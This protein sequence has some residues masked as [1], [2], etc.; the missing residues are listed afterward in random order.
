MLQALLASVASIQSQQTRMSVIGNNLANVNT[1]AYK[2][3]DL[4]FEDMISQ[5]IQGATAPSGNLGG[6]NPIQYGMGVLVAGTEVNNQQGSLN[7]TNRPSD[8]AIQGDGYFMVGGGNAMGYTRDGGFALDSAGDLVQRSTGLRL[9][10]WTAD[11]NGTIDTTKPI[12]A[13]S[14]LNIQVGG[15]SSVQA[16]T[17]VT[18]GGNLKSSAAT[19]D[20]WSASVRV[21]DAKGGPHDLTVKF[22]KDAAAAAGAP[23][24]TANTWSWTATEGTTAIGSSTSSGNAALAFDVNGKLLNPTALGNVQLDPTGTPPGQSLTIDFSKTTQLN[25]DSSVSATGQNGFPVGTLESYSVDSNGVITGSFTNGLSKSLG[26]VAMANFSNPDGMARAGN[27]L[28]SAT[29]NSGTPMVGTANSSG[30]GSMA[31]GYLEQS[32]VDMST[33]LTDLIVAQ[34]GFEANTKVVS[35]V[36]EM[37]QTLIQMKQG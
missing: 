37:L 8:L 19:T 25:T 16:T 13:A 33:Q 17:Q 4:T 10:G 15:T 18:L 30:R 2:S 22:T 1:T 32:N 31:A 36:N 14:A 9:L 11:A 28:W 12:T 21:Y 3:S 34:R 29:S 5:T 26:Q 23:A 24:G 6:R 7:A 27:N 35:T 20:S